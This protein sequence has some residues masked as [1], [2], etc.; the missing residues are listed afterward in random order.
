MNDEMR[1][2]LSAFLGQYV[3]MNDGQDQAPETDMEIM[4]AIMLLL[5]EEIFTSDELR[6]ECLRD[7]GVILPLYMLGEG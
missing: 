4:G 2:R 5:R 6:A 3:R 1:R 7:C